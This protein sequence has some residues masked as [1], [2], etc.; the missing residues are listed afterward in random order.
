MNGHVFNYGA[1]TCIKYEVDRGFDS[2]FSGTYYVK[3]DAVDCC[4]SSGGIP[5]VKKWDI[6][7]GGKMLHDKIQYLGKQDTTGLN[8]EPVKD[9]DVWFEE[10]NLP[11]AKGVKANYTYF[12]TKNGTDVITHRI[13]YGVTQQTAGVI[14]YGDFQV[15]HN[16]TNFRSVFEPPA[17]CLKPNVLTCGET[18]TKK[19]DEQYFAKN[20]VVKP[21]EPACCFCSAGGDGDG[22]C[23]TVRQCD[24]RKQ[25]GYK[26]GSGTGGCQYVPEGPFGAGCM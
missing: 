14:L 1:N 11:F 13:E 19:W 10:F 21:D 20:P 22:S 4:K 17:E 2:K 8:N 12:V 3:C 6:G 5:D 15:Q 23:A 16:I 18:E 26:C 7:E 25:K 24:A 9:A